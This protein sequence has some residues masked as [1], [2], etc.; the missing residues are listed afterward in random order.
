MKTTQP[1]GFCWNAGNEE[2]KRTPVTT[3]YGEKKGGF[4]NREKEHVLFG[5][6][7]IIIIKTKDPPEAKERTILLYNTK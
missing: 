4:Y 6:V 7:C 5:K 1:A 2:R 3:F